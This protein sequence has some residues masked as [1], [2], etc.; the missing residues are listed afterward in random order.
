MTKTANNTTK[1]ANNTTKT[2]ITS[3][4]IPKLIINGQVIETTAKQVTC[5]IKGNEV[6]LNCT[7]IA[8]VELKDAY[9][10]A[11][12][13]T[14]GDRNIEVVYCKVNNRVSATIYI[15]KVLAF[16]SLSIQAVF[17]VLNTAYGLSKS[18]LNTLYVRSNGTRKQAGKSVSNVVVNNS[19]DF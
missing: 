18:S 19:F 12:N 7:Y 9:S 6:T 11:F 3:R 8:E 5:N 1:T 2:S 15:N 17:T 16:S 10:S 13:V 4:Y 14:T